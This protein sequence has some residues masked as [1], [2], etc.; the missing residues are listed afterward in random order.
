MVE[1]K[2]IDY[3]K[4]AV[5]FRYH[6]LVK[7]NPCKHVPVAIIVVLVVNLAI[8]KRRVI[9]EAEVEVDKVNILI[10]IV[11]VV[12]D[13]VRVVSQMGFSIFIVD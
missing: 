3:A 10:D 11:D 8:F 12:I 6:A 7:E 9:F 5:D 4:E 2:R 1:A 13:G